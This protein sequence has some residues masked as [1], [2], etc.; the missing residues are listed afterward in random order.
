[1]TYC[2]LKRKLVVCDEDNVDITNVNERI[3]GILA[4]DASNST[5]MQYHGKAHRKLVDFIPDGSPLYVAP[6]SSDL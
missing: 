3:Q 5:D 2:E 1:M 4:W 6:D